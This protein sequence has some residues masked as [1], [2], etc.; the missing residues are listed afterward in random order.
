MFLNFAMKK[1]KK[2]L[3]TILIQKLN[4]RSYSNVTPRFITDIRDTIKSNDLMHPDKINTKFNDLSFFL[5]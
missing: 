3:E 4:D 1:K 2:P 5:N